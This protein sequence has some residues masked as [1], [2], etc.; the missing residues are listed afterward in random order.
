M[1]ELKYKTLQLEYG[2]IR[3][4]IDKR[5]SLKIVNGKAK[6]CNDTFTYE[7]SY[8]INGGHWQHS[9]KHIS[10]EEARQKLYSL[11]G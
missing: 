9:E 1:P 3:Y 2:N 7:L 4:R 8:S 11:A 5:G 6:R 10:A